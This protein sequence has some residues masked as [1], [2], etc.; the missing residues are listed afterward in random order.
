MEY[1][2]MVW[3][4]YESIKI[5]II[6]PCQIV[7]IFILKKIT[8]NPNVSCM[9]FDFKKTKFHSRYL[10]LDDL[11]LCLMLSSGKP[12]K[13]IALA[14]Q[15][16]GDKKAIRKQGRF[17]LPLSLA[18]HTPLFHTDKPDFFSALF[19]ISASFYHYSLGIIFQSTRRPR[20]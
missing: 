18:R 20:L 2:C 17:S 13:Q 6:I 12:N 1:T 5:T 10:G 8:S 11:M 4:F 3:N 15:K 14:S 7:W 9:L 19:W 16:T